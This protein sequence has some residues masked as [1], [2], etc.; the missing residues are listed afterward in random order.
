MKTRSTALG[1]TFVFASSRST[2]SPMRP[3]H[4]RRRDSEYIRRGTANVFCAVEPLAGRH[5]LEATPNRKAPAF[6]RMLRRVERSYPRVST[7]HLVMDN[8]SDHDTDEV[9][10]W[11]DEHPRWTRHFTPKHASWLNQ[12]ENAFSI[13]HRRVLTGGTWTSTQELQEAIYSY[14]IWHNVHGKPFKWSYRPK[15]W[16]KNHGE[17]SAEGN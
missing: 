16:S 4:V 14:L 17:S 13:L 8:L 10:D 5:M 1:A 7:I 15:S 9:N 2:H 11:F 3:G 6:A 12:I